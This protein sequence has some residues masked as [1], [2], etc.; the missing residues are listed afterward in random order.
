MCEVLKPFKY[1]QS[2][3]NENSLPTTKVNSLI[4]FEKTNLIIL[5]DT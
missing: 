2:L 3:P 4:L 1:I 5:T